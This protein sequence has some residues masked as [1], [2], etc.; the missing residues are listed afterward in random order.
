[1]RLFKKWFNPDYLLTPVLVDTVSLAGLEIN[2]R[3]YLRP[4]KYEVGEIRDFNVVPRM[5]SVTTGSAMS[6]PGGYIYELEDA[7]YITNYLDKTLLLDSNNAFIEES[8]NTMKSL[9]SFNWRHFRRKDIETLDIVMPFR[10][11]SNNYYHT[12]L[13][14]APR[15]YSLHTEMMRKYKKIDVLCVGKIS[16][17]EQYLFD[18][19]LPDNAN[20]V[21]LQ[22]KS[23]YLLKHCLFPSFVTSQYSGYVPK[24]IL[25]FFEQR[26]MPDRPRKSDKLIYITRKK[27]GVRKLINEEDVISALQKYGFQEYCLEDLSF[28]QQIE[29]FYDARMIVGPHGAG[30]TNLVFSKGAA[31]LEL[32]PFKYVKP[33]YY[34]LTRCTGGVYDYLSAEGSEINKDFI[35]DVKDI[36]NKVMHVLT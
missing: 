18:R 29:L 21:I 20:L 2:G 19:L 32:F 9:S 26:L 24:E 28:P 1:M 25:N 33:S 23:A 34:Y 36:E 27:A 8:S 10:S 14:N 3:Q 11:V 17:I 35:I 22:D 7:R 16:T 30:F 4:E 13:D 15:L 5:R 6:T 12:L 31:V